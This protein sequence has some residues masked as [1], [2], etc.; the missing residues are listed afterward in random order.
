MKQ[1]MPYPSAS[2]DRAGEIQIEKRRRQRRTRKKL[3][4]KKLM[5][6]TSSKSFPTLSTCPR[7]SR[8]HPH[9]EV[10]LH[11]SMKKS[12]FDSHSRVYFPLYS[13]RYSQHQTSSSKR[14]EERK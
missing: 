11:S 1:R 13:A 5:K 8:R 12:Y 10:A 2:N 9:D 4:Q 6:T 3:R 14:K 7:R